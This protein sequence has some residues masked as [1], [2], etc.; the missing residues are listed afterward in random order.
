MW[1]DSKDLVPDLDHKIADALDSVAVQRER[2]LVL[3]QADSGHLH[4]AALYVGAKI[5]V[6]FDPVDEHHAVGLRGDP[7]H[8]H[9]HPA[10]RLSELDDLH[11]RTYRRAAEFFRYAQRLQDLDLSLRRGP[12]VAAHRG[13]DKGLGL[14]LLQDLDEGT[15]DPIYL[16]DAAAS[17]GERH[18]HPGFD[19]RGDLP[20]PQLLP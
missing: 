7:V 16:G 2:L 6:G 13:H 18:A 11:R 3:A 1:P 9:G 12:A 10:P 19:G 17:R 14:H 15:Y 8:V 5:R 20:P 4:Q